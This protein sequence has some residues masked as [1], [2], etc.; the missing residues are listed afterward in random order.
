[1][2]DVRE[3]AWFARRHERGRVA[4]ARWRPVPAAFWATFGDGTLPCVVWVVRRRH[5]ATG[6]RSLCHETALEPFSSV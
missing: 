1:M 2:L 4:C 3:V 6:P 5:E